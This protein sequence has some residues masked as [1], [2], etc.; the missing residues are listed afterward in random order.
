ME[1][2]VLVGAP[3]CDLYE[4]CFDEFLNAIK[5]L[6]YKN[7][8]ILL[9]DNSKDDKYFNKIKDKVNV[10]RIEYIEKMRERVVKS[11]NILRKEVLDK[12]YDYLLVLDQDVIPPPNVIEQLI[13][14]KKDAVSALFFGHH[15]IGV[16]KIVMPF[17]WVFIE[18]K[19][20]WGE[21]TPNQEVT[22][23]LFHRSL[24]R[25]CHKT[26]IVDCIFFENLS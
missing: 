21:R 20:F 12:K 10:V 22:W 5:N 16:G 18:K 11:H 23:R 19:D 24:R 15:N 8:D 4:Y 25:I 6:T 13:R 26:V 17:A 14:H 9:V 3:V 1:P 7:Y 2:R